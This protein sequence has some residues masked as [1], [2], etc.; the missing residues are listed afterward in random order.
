MTTLPPGPYT[1]VVSGV[2]GVT[3]VG[4]VEV[5]EVDQPDTPLINIS[6][7]GLVGT[8]FD[9]MIGGFVVQGSGSQTVAIRAIGPSLT[10]FGITGA[11]ANPTMQLVRISDNTVIA[12]N[13]DWQTAANAAQLQSAGF[14]P[15]NPLESAILMT[16]QPGAYTAVVSGVG[17]TSGVGL[18]EVYKVTP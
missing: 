15:G 18:V 13:D 11:L 2:G 4:L 6:T 5:Y 8:N 7:R 10:Q 14:A 3:G 12:T 9:V 17:G 1:A 16:L